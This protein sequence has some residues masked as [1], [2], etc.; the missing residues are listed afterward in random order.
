MPPPIKIDYKSKVMSPMPGAVVSVS[1][2]P[3][4][5]IVDGQEILVL[6]AMK[7]Q[8]IIKSERDGKVKNVLVKKGQSVGVDEIMI[9]FV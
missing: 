7:M 1:V 4:D 3:G 2:K 9:E 6:E 8:N 5:V